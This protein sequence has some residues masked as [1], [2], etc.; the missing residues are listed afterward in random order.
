VV[1]ANVMRE[2][3]MPQ[4]CRKGAQLRTLLGPISV[5]GGSGVAVFSR[6]PLNDWFA[7]HISIGPIAKGPAEGTECLEWE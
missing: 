5:F 4:M 3:A 7:F 1:H 6:V 2:A